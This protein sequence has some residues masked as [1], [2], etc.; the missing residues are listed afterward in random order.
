MSHEHRWEN[1]GA[2]RVICSERGCSETP[3]SVIATLTAEQA[4]KEIEKRHM[5]PHVTD[6]DKLLA[7]PIKRVQQEH[8]DGCVVACYAMLTQQSF[9]EAMGEFVDARMWRENHRG[10]SSM[11][12]VQRL[13]E[14]G[15]WSQQYYPTHGHFSDEEDREQFKRS[16]WPPN[17]WAPYHLVCVT[18][19]NGFHSV[20]MLADGGV[21]D[22]FTS[23]TRRLSDYASVMEVIGLRPPDNNWKPLIAH[24]DR[25]ALEL[26]AARKVVA[27][28]IFKGKSRHRCLLCNG[29]WLPNGP[30]QHYEPC[31]VAAYDRVMEKQR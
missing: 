6:I 13:T 2:N 5:E 27:E 1:A 7:E 21:L 26:E 15:W 16:P 28:Q 30:T 29:A 20:V 23:E 22:P 10:L 4:Q 25:L 8:P 18:N 9:A 19:P 17:P 14:R 3:Q 24:I 11:W 31:P 12:C